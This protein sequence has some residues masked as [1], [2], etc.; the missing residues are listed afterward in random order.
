MKLY[1]P[2]KPAEFIPVID[3]GPSFSLDIE[4]RKAVAWEIHKACRDTGFFYVK[5]HGVPPDL[6]ARH[7][8]LS[9][10]FF[11]LPAEVKA[12]VAVSKSSCTRGFEAMAAQTL[13]EGSP[14]DLKEGFLMGVDLPLDHPDVVGGVPNTG[15]NQWPA[16]PPAFK[17][18]FNEYM[19]YMVRLGSHL[20]RCIA[21]S[22]ELPESYF[23]EGLADPLYIGRLLHYP[24]HPA[25]AAFNQLGAGAHTDWGMLTLLLQDDVGGLEIENAAGDW[26]KAPYVQDAFIINLGEMMPVLTNGLYHSTPHRVLNNSSGRDRYSCPTF[27]DP[28]Y[29]Y[30][31]KCVPTC[32]PKS[33]SPLF[34]ETT[35][36]QHIANMY[37]KT[38]GR[39]A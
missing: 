39:A 21:L 9:R 23:D 7:L 12:E 35:V 18:Q 16:D 15:P 20:M 36:G 38:Y 2:P 25:N 8:E 28:N 26:I 14:P 5:N 24:P 32:M 22:L 1:T 29:H 11:S 31:V 33:G 6:M 10:A 3:L 34:A 30:Q 17:R 19:G 13:D 37:A 4:D 27:F